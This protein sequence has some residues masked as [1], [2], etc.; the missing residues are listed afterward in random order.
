ML[1]AVGCVST[2]KL[3]PDLSSW[4][5]TADCERL[6]GRRRDS[7]QPILAELAFEILVTHHMRA[8]AAA[9]LPLCSQS[10]DRAVSWDATVLPCSVTCKL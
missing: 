10:S 4:S 7:S 3:W 1:Q 5:V 9:A 6:G 2:D 8:R